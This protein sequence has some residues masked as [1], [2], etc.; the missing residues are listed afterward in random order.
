[1]YLCLIQLPLGGYPFKQVE[2]TKMHASGHICE[3]KSGDVK[4]L[5][6]PSGSSCMPCYVSL[7]SSADHEARSSSISFD[8]EMNRPLRRGLSTAST[9][10]TS[11]LIVFSNFLRNRLQ[12][13]LWMASIRCSVEYLCGLVPA[14]PP[15]TGLLTAGEGSDGEGSSV[16][17]IIGGGTEAECKDEEVG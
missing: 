5:L 17:M 8:L 7:K 10:L 13:Y 11:Y 4:K 14:P 1:M 12:R 15:T 6:L 9:F 2:F 16:L 3:N